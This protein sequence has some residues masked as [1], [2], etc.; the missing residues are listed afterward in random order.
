MVVGG[1]VKTYGKAVPDLR[2]GQENLFPRFETY[3]EQV[4]GLYWFP[5]Y[6]RALDTLQFS[7]GAQRMRM[8]LKYDNYK[9]FQADVKLTYGDAV[10]GDGAK[11]GAPKGDGKAPALDPKLNPTPKKK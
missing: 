4:D 10:E 5:T 2:K 9:K 8:I 3:R 1:F 6:T 11:D 7:S